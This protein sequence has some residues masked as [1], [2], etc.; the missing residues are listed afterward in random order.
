MR[1]TLALGDIVGSDPE[2]SPAGAVEATRAV[3][4]VLLTPC[5]C[6]VPALVHVLVTGSG[7]TLCPVVHRRQGKD[8]KTLC[9]KQ[10]LQNIHHLVSFHVPSPFP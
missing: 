5:V 7:G 9:Q 3:H 8:N 4:A 10:L 2:P 1:L 6:K